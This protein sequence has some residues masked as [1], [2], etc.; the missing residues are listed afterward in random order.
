MPLPLQATVSGRPAGPTIV[1][2]HGFG[3]DRTIW[4]RLLPAFADDHRL[5]TFDH[6][7]PDAADQHAGGH[8]TLGGYA[9][10]LVALLDAIGASE[11]TYVGHSV[12]GTIGLLADI[13]APGRLARIVTIGSSA[14]YLDDDGYVGGFSPADVDDILAAI[15]DNY[16]A[17]SSASVSGILN[18]PDRPDLTVELEERFHRIAPATARRFARATFLA[19]VR[20]QLAEVRAHVVVVQARED[21]IVPEEAARYLH[22][23]LP[24]STYVRLAATG[25]CPMLSAPDELIA[26]LAAHVPRPCTTP[27][28]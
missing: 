12:G 8:A 14:R 11:V 3:G 4:D 28:R 22:D 5:V 23:H 24:S 20:E 7:G 13:A 15:D 18:T 19:D 26:V 10:D 1:F 2:G 27:V 16:P 9:E 25:H 21:A 6:D 17:W